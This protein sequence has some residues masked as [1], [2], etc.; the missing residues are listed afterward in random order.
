M[1]ERVVDFFATATEA[2]HFL[3]Q[4]Y[5]YQR[6]DGFVEEERD[7]TARLRYL[8]SRVGVEISWYF[9]NS[10]IGVSFI[11]LLQPGMLPDFWAAFGNYP[12]AAKAISL[13]T[14]V[15]MQGHLE[16]PDFLLQYNGSRKRNK[17]AKLIEM[18]MPDILAGLARATQT[19]AADILEGDISIFPQVMAYYAAQLKGRYP[20]T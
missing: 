19:Y 6:Q 15:E 4:Q 14:L 9:A 1:N 17:R 11:E 3:E 12:G 13:Y 10:A 20:N 18:R 5:G 8:G 2:F 16:D 7:A